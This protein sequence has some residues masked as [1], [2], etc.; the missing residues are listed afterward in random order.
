MDGNNMKD[1]FML[2]KTQY[3]TLFAYHWHTSQR[4]LEL[5]ARLPEAGYKASTGYGR[6]SIHELL[7]HI[8]NA[9]HSWRIA[10]ESGQQSESLPPEAYPDLAAMRA[11]FESEQRSWE[12]LMDAFSPDEIAAVRELTNR[13]GRTFPIPLWRVLQHLILHGMQHHTELA[14]LLTE[15]GQSPGDIDFIFFRD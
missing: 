10:V 5:A 15:Q 2:I 12:Q 8:L 1:Q 11:G 3:Q 4:I 6:G 13:R 7:F 9:D 14:Q